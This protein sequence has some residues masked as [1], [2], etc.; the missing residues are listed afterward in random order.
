MPSIS[1]L[2]SFSDLLSSEEKNKDQSIVI[3]TTGIENTQSVSVALTSNPKIS[4]IQ[5]MQNNSATV[6]VP[7]SDLQQ[8]TDGKSYEIV[9]S[10]SNIFGDTRQAV[11]DFSIEVPPTSDPDPAPPGITTTILVG[12]GTSMFIQDENVSLGIV[13]TLNFTGA[14]VEAIVTNEIAEIVIDE[15]TSTTIINNN[16]IGG[17]SSMFIEHQDAPL[18]I[19]TTMNFTGTGITVVVADETAEII[20]D[21]YDEHFDGGYFTD[22]QNR[23]DDP[24]NAGLGSGNT[25][26]IEYEDQPVGYITS[27]NFIGEGVSANVS[28]FAG[29]VTIDGDFDGGSY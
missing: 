8:L 24:D 29:D 21:E 25:I 17:G 1:L 18:G 20:V 4:Y 12:G 16:F 28:N 26:L 19:V 2:P 6:I 5:R 3:N 14:G 10:V 11:F 27:I 13:T 15:A 23:D 9:A 22:P 7:A